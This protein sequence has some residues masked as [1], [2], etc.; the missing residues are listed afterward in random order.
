[1]T[2]FAA[3]KRNSYSLNH[4]FIAMK[5]K[6]LSWILGIV[7]P[8]ILHAQTWIDL[9]DA[10]VT[11]P[12]FDGN[13]KTGWTWT[14][15][16]GSQ[17][18]GYEGMEFWNGHFDFYQTI[19]VPNGLYRL[20]MQGY[21]RVGENN[22]CYYE[23]LNGE[24]QVTGYLYANDVLVPVASIYSESL[25][26]S[27]VN[28][29]WDSGNGYFPNTMESGAY[30]FAQGKYNNK[31]E[32]EVTQEELT[33][34]VKC[35]EYRSGNWIMFDN[36]K[37]EYYGTVTY[38]TGVQLS[39]SSLALTLGQTTQLTATI[40]PSN[41]TYRGIEWSSS[42][43]AVATVDDKG[44]IVTMGKGTTVITA[45]ATD[46]SN[47]KGSC[48]VTVE[49]N[50][51][52][53][54]SLIINEIQ[55]ANVD[56]FVDP[57]FNYG[58][59]IE[60][61][62]PTDKMVSLYGFYLSDDPNDVTK[63][64]LQRY[65]GTIPAHGYKVIWF[66]HRSDR[67]PA[68]VDGKLNVEGG[69]IYVSNSS[70]ELVSAQSYPAAFTRTAYART[71]DGGN[72]W[73]TT[74]TPTPGKSNAGSTFS[75]NRL[76]APVVDK[77][78][79][80]F[81]ST[82]T[83][84]VEIP[85]G[86]TLR[87]T[88]DGTTPTTSNGFTSQDGRFTISS[89]TMYRFRLF[90]NGY[91]PSRVVTRTYILQDKD[92]TLPIISVVTD[93]VNLYDD[94][95]GI[96][97]KGVNG[98][99]GNGQSSPCNWNMEWD[100]PVNFE[101]ITTEG[102]MVINMEANM[103]MCG[104]W[105]RA[106]SPHSFK[107]K[108][109]K[110]YE[111]QNYIP[112]QIFPE[113][114]HLKHKTL[115]IRN[116][117]NDTDCRIKDAALQTI[118]HTSGLDMDGQACQPVVH[119]I[120]GQYIGLLNIREPNNRHFVE[121]NYGLEEEEID[122][123]EMSP[124]SNYVQKCGTEESFMRWYE[125]S[126]NA[127]NTATYEEICGMVDIDEYANYMAVEMYL[128]GTDWPQNNIKGFKPIREGGKFR[129]VLFDLDGAFATSSPFQYMEDYKQVH[130]FDY[131][132][133]TGTRITEE[134]KWTTIFFNMLKNETFRKKFIDTFCL[135]AGSVFT[136]ERCNAII[137]S[138]AHNTEAMLAYEGKSPWGTANTLKNNLSKRQQTLINAMKSFS[139]MNL[140]SVTEQKVSLSANISQARL[141]V[142]D[143]EV[144][145]N[146]FNG[147]LFAP[148]TLKATAPAGYRFVGWKDLNSATTN[149][150]VTKG[151]RWSYYD[152][153]S[154][155]GTQWYESINSS[156]FKGYAPLGYFTSDSNNGR[157]YQTFLD[158]G[159]DA[160]N[161]RPTYYFI[162]Q[163]S[164][165]NTPS[166]NDVYTL[167]Y[168]VD[169]GMVVY[170]NGV[171]AGRYLMNEGSVTYDTYASTYAN[172]NPDTGS[173][174]L[175]TNLFKK[176]ENIIAVEVHNNNGG[177]SDIYFDAELV[178]YTTGEADANYVCYDE[179]Y[180]MPASG[181]FNFV[182]CYEAIPADE[183]P[184]VD[185]A[186]V[187]I[188]EISA[189][190]SIYVNATYFKKNDWIELY[191]T[192]AQAIDVAGMYLS[193]NIKNPTKYQIPTSQTVNTVIPARGFMVIWADKLSD[194]EQLHAP[195]KLAKEGGCVLLTAADQSWAD[196]LFYDMHDSYVSVGIYPDGGSDVYV[197]NTPT[198]HAPNRISSYAEYLIE[199]ELPSYIETPSYD[200]AEELAILYAGRTLYVRGEESD[201]VTIQLYTPSGQTA[202]QT[203]LLI[204]GGHA[205]TSLAHLPAGIYIVRAENER[206]ESAVQK[207]ILTR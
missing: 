171:E 46:G 2:N 70:G 48:T 121:A 115:Q 180:T 152:Q 82:L 87:Y 108:A 199:S 62:N 38:A 146:K 76:E 135:V 90:Q 69:T 162:K 47:A 207:L 6:A 29:L 142:N 144:P 26:Q 134:I 60:L 117:G 112:Y 9:T 148:I 177:S 11:N 89:T 5:R 188:N 169:D 86:A 122:Q 54:A 17:N 79:C 139:R 133:D 15:N 65:G 167:N 49:N 14:S 32:V 168:T 191:N 56:M 143:M 99:T 173:M 190:N 31:L 12:R 132:Y 98:R 74:A 104:G 150:V 92:Y 182:A 67:A 24:E 138:M 78:A 158:Y 55:A 71:T 44:N 131:I 77:D 42:N 203:S 30:F 91:L 153:G 130:T 181:D 80:L 95:L 161:K 41:A 73:G 196:T 194:V 113:K 50:E 140:S 118:V 51:A 101:Y 85:T 147:S 81:S 97:V 205:T 157:G 155:D 156:W 61:Y 1:M 10:Y 185:G 206:G 128:G 129:F 149:T 106:W 25:D 22:P 183:M 103:E 18:S 105:S 141:M 40:L 37:L 21:Y 189:D 19:S 179:E 136:P 72:E 116:G 165:A 111:G 39:E 160:S 123:F 145:T 33:I 52:T 195:F 96:Y 164:L 126:A 127:A 154:Q 125:L 114:S 198:I 75:G 68:Q 166:D 110:L 159:S 119:F 170:I 27:S 204:S 174:E 107:I 45:T 20:S 8:T 151:S 43:K 202:M 192:T 4:K 57:S 84:Q 109:N 201:R 178:A 63:Y 137:D 100:R 88:T 175:P 35:Q 102:E 172:G 197:M 187:R 163:F 59:W 53:A 120:N 36:F 34:G 93:P 7:L 16:A 83:I 124:D 64:P 23:Y 3:Q 193:D 200:S 58:G 186:P 176:G 66:D 28:G 94:S 184:E 13:L